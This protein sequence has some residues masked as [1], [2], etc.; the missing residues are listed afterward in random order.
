MDEFFKTA[1]SKLQLLVINLVPIAI[2]I[3]GGQLVKSPA[4]QS[5][6]RYTP[7]QGHFIKLMIYNMRHILPVLIGFLFF[8]GCLSRRDNNYAVLQKMADAVNSSRPIQLDSE[9][10][11]DSATANANGVLRFYQ[12][13][14]FDTVTYDIREFKK[15]LMSMAVNQL[16][17]SRDGKALHALA[18]T[19]EYRY[20][21]TTGAPLFEFA[22]TPD[23]YAASARQ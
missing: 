13:I 14:W 23:Q 3:P 11:I 7:R 15:E 5:L 6:E 21:D 18:A 10:R 19:V 22:I 17:K 12:T 4:A 20:F 8:S 1:R 9:T 16:K 2:G